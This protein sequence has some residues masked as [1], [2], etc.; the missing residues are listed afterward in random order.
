MIFQVFG[1]LISILHH[2]FQRY[3]GGDTSTIGG[4]T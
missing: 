2:R 4:L 1:E 3:S